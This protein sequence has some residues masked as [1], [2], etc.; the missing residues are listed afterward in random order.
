M[1]KGEEWNYGEKGPRQRWPEFIQEDYEDDG[2]ETSIGELD[3]TWERR[4]EE[5]ERITEVTNFDQEQEERVSRGVS[6]GTILNQHQDVGGGV[7]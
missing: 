6:Y 1:E 3:D 4:D 7:S 5:E 2:S